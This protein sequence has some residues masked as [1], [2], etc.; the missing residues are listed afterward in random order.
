MAIYID[1]CGTT[2]LA[3]EVRDAMVAFMD[4][5]AFANPAA[6]HHVAGRAAFEAVETARASIA[7]QL[8]AKPEWI[9]F[10][11]GA[12]EANNIVIHGFAK[13][14]R[15]HGCR[16]LVGAT[17][18]KSVLDA[19][20]DLKDSGYCSVEVI[21]VQK[22]DALIDMTALAARLA[23][24][25]KNLATL[26][27]VMW[28]N[29]EVPARNPVEQIAALCV[30]YNAFWHCDAVQGLVREKIDARSLGA[31]SIVFAPHKIYGPKGI[32][33][34]VIPERTPMLRLEAP[35]QGGEQERRLRPGT[36][37]TLA[38]VG[39]AAALSVHERRRDE[40]L[41]HLRA[42][43][44]AFIN[45]MAIRVPGFHLTIPRCAKC[46]GIVNFY[47]HNVDAQSL[48]H[49]V[50]EKVCANRGASCSG[51]GGEKIR[52][53]PGAL[54]LPVEVAANVV[55]VS[56]GFVN[57]LEDARMAAEIF[58]AAAIR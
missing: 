13:R 3:R 39:T 2:P 34:L 43:D 22:A 45:T 52:H 40:L 28:S 38:I 32:G 6:H 46:P 51:A 44:E 19:A 8:N 29:N 57:S 12:S 36:V 41:A 5:G 20:L 58:A 21:P 14:F 31:S 50:S 49:E 1:H 11:G 33:V 17:E 4:G 7:S 37:N 55:R 27:A 16:I 23:D 35:F 47:I 15:H 48:V 18:H 26:V 56:F 10:S 30:K 54:G 24:N 25:P 53:V 42:C 9:H